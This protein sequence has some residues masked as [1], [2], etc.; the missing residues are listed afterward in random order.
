MGNYKRALA[1]SIALP[2]LVSC[3]TTD[4]LN[5]QEL[6]T[7][8]GAVV[9]AILGAAIA[10][11]EGL[12]IGAAL[13]GIAGNL[14][15]YTLDEE[16]QRALA[17]RTDY[18]LNYARVGQ[19]VYWK[20]DHSNASA[21]ITPAEEMQ[22]ERLVTFK[23]NKASRRAQTSANLNV[24]SGPGVAYAVRQSLPAGTIVSITGTTK[25]GW[26]RIEKDGRALGFINSAYLD[27]MDEQKKELVITQEDTQQDQDVTEELSVV[28][29]VE[30]RR[31]RVD[32]EIN[33]Q[34]T[35]SYVKNCKGSDG[36]W[37]G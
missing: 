27:E 7:G 13:G 14:M 3:T 10:G 12:I 30:C 9:G 18:A 5:K 16:D 6:G 15:G 17:A 36:S 29:N 20:S 19:T 22:E 33:G 31:V 2:L 8:I 34:K 25:N 26:S 4:G 21:E 1:M 11:D 35:E 23:V 37:G 32:L 28:A 24:R